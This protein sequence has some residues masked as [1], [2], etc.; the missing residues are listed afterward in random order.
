MKTI[1]ISAEPF[2]E[3]L[4]ESDASMWDIFAQMIDGEEKELIFLDEKD[5]ILFNYI[6]PDTF[7]RLQQDRKDFSENYNQLLVR[8][9]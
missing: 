6:L 1:H 7:E 9:N 3:K 5:E 4:K 2:F 8:K